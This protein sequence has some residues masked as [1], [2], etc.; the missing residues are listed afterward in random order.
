M[1]VRCVC[2]NLMYDEDPKTCN[3]FS[4]YLNEDYY[5]LLENSHTVEELIDNMPEGDAFWKC[6]N[7]GRLHFFTNG[8][9][10]IFNLETEL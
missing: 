3:V 5:K 2:N 7:C 6:T 10:R 8:K 1:K 9:I 4:T